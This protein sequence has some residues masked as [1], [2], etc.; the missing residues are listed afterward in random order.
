MKKSEKPSVDRRAIWHLIKPYWVSEERGKAWG[1]LAIIIALVLVMVYINVLLND[2]NRNLYDSLQNKNYDAFRHLLVQFSYFAFSYITVATARIYLTQSLQIRW[3]TWMTDKYM[4]NWLRYQAYY[5]MEQNHV[6]D[7]PD[8]RIAEDL[9]SLS[10]STISLVLG[11]IS[12]TVTLVSFVGILWTISGPIGFALLQRDWVIPGYMVWFAIAYA[13]VGS[14]L[15]WWIGKPLVSQTFNQQ[16]FEAN[17]RFGLFRVREY[18]E[19]I[20][21]YRGEQRERGELGLRFEDI[22]QNWWAIMNTTKRLNIATNFYGQFAIIF[23]MLVAAPRYFS[24]AIS[25][26]VL[27]QI[28]SAFGQVQDALSWFI[29][30]FTTLADWKASINRLAGFNLVV[31]RLQQQPSGVSVERGD[32]G[33]IVFDQ[34]D[35]ALPDG[36]TLIGGMSGTI[37]PGR[38]ILISGPSGCGKS[39]LLRAV[40]GIWP[41]GAGAIRT[42]QEP[43]LMFVPQTSYLPIGTLRSALAYPAAD[44]H[45]TDAQLCHYLDLCRLPHLKDRLDD[46]ANWA[47]RLSPGEQQRLA[48]ARVFLT[49]PQ[50]V[51]LDEASS[52]MDGETEEALYELLQQE[53]PLAAVVSVAHRETVARYHQQRWHISNRN[54][55]PGDALSRLSI[56]PI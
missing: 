34:V 50:V 9:Q 16:R 36:R 45:Y 11:F 17:F 21:L 43:A 35:L 52:A 40:A 4:A 24:G 46:V 12:S 49:R 22:R 8:Q 14:W 3:R 38:R 28:N 26:G 47:K 23:P 1:L 33:A 29:N 51:F 18:A 27:M 20:A 41:Y 44:N 15:I 5:R 48:F 32:A 10:S 31:E 53:L 37:E 25:L 54:N 13:G 56:D 42:P 6:A 19:A 30:A 55:P 7:N 39:T 2:W